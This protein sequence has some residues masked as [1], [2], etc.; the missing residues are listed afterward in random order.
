MRSDAPPPVLSDGYTDVPVGKVAAVVTYLE[1]HDPP[2]PAGASAHA[3][4]G[5]LDAIA[6]DLARYRALYRRIG[7]PW[8]WFSRLAM[9]EAELRAILVNPEVDAFALTRGGRDIGLL[10]LDF[11]TKGEC[12]LSFLGLVPEAIGSGAG[13]FLVE[14]AIARAFGRPVQRLWVHTCS[15]DHPAALGFYLRAGFMPYRRAIEIAD[16]PRLTGVLPR[17]AAPQVPVIER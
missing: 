17:S 1:M 13:R 6:G 11:R 2:S 4:A 5:G 16:D 12:E 14:S 9:P 8:L 15:L 3:S 10:E 7:E